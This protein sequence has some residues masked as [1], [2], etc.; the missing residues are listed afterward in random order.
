MVM[1]IKCSQCKQE[2]NALVIGT[3]GI[4]KYDFVCNT[5]YIKNFVGEDN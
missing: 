4:E 3:V 1:I 2:T 5:C